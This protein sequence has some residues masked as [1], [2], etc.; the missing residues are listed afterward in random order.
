MFLEVQVLAREQLGSRRWHQSSCRGRG[1]HTEQPHS[2]S[3]YKISTV[4]FLGSRSSSTRSIYGQEGSDLHSARS[5]GPHM[6]ASPVPR[7]PLEVQADRM[8]R[9]CPLSAV[10]QN[11]PDAPLQMSARL[12]HSVTTA[13]QCSATGSGARHSSRLEAL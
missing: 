7:P 5:K 10:T 1:F 6:A 11:K 9:S 3:W 4:A 2:T 12:A 8:K 13:S